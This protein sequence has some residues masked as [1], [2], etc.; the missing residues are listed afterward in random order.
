MNNNN[1]LYIIEAENFSAAIGDG[2]FTGIDT[3]S[4]EF[5]YYMEGRVMKSEILMNELSKAEIPYECLEVIANSQLNEL[6]SEALIGRI[7]DNDL[8]K[9]EILQYIET[10]ESE[11]VQLEELF[12]DKEKDENIETAKRNVMTREGFI[13]LALDTGMKDTD[14]I[15]DLDSSEEQ[16]LN[17][18]E[19]ELYEE[20]PTLVLE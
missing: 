18:K 17:N 11:K 6:D 15:D 10:S 8:S 13:E 16:L 14:L 12:V 9:S 4:Q 1:L 5:P 3:N 2:T 20:E 7:K 19:S